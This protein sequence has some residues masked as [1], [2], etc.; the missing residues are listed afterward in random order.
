ME[1]R[2]ASIDRGKVTRTMSRGSHDVCAIY[3]ALDANLCGT[4]VWCTVNH[5]GAAVRQQ[6]TADR[7]DTFF[8]LAG[9]E[10]DT[11]RSRTGR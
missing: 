3:A 4:V 10:G 7:H 1:Q 9:A 6:Q 5:F 8:C 11:A 2:L